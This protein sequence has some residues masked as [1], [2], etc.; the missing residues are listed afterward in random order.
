MK[1]QSTSSAL[2]VAPGK[3]ATVSEYAEEEAEY[4]GIKLV[5][6]FFPVHLR[7]NMTLHT[8]QNLETRKASVKIKSTNLE[9]PTF[10][11]AEQFIDKLLQQ[12]IFDSD[13]IVRSELLNLDDSDITL[14]S[15]QRRFS[16]ATGIPKSHFLRINQA[17]HAEMLLLQGKTIADAT[18]QAGY[19]DQSHLIRSLKILRGFTPSEIR[20]SSRR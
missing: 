14:R 10:D 6:G 11:N 3:I 4:F 7:A 12:G 9:I 18:H 20:D 1:N 2:L 19:Y 13:P 17:I 8:V 5:P 15:I 16:R